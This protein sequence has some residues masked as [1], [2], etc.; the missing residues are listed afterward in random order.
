M[1]HHITCECSDPGCKGHKGQSECTGESNQILYRVDMQDETG[2]AMCDVCADD[3]FASGLFTT[4][5]DDD[6]L[7]NEEDAQ[8]GL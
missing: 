1:T 6:Y 5:D 4:K 2:T 7:L 8:E 3:A